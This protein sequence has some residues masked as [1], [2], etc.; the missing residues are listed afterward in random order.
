MASLARRV[1]KCHTRS[2]CR[3]VRAIIRRMRLA[4]KLTLALVFA[5]SAVLT[6]HGVLAARRELA[7]FEGSTQRDARAMG[8]TL[9]AVVSEI[10]RTEGETRAI[11]TIE[12]AN[13]REASVNF[14]FV[15]LDPA[16]PR[17]PSIPVE[18][19]GELV[20]GRAIVFR[21]VQSHGRIVTYVPI[22]AD[23]S[24][25]GAIEVTSSLLEQQNY[26]RRSVL[27]VA[28][29]T[30]ATTG[31]AAAVTILLGAFFVGRPMRQLIEKAR[32]IGAGDLSG[33]LELR[34]RDELGE[35]ASEINAMC[36]R[37]A[38]ARAARMRAVDELRHAHRLAVVGRLAAGVAHELGTPL[39]VVTG[40]ANMIASGEVEGPAAID[41][42]NNVLSAA[43]RMTR[44]IRAL[45]DFA[46]RGPVRK[47][48]QSLEHVVRQVMTLIS[49]ITEK[50]RIEV[51]V[52]VPPEEIVVD[53]DAAQLQQALTNLAING[54]DAM[55]R[56]GKLTI[57]LSNVVARPPPEIGGPAARYATIAVRDEG[58][59]ID[60]AVLEQIFEPFFTTKSAG[61]GTGL[62]LSVSFGIVQEHGGWIAV[63]SLPGHGACFTVFLPMRAE[64]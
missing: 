4:R 48:P 52:Q 5:V 6:V 50:R 25:R 64:S 9:V 30:A 26:V 62:G 34:Q 55:G 41:A 37:L 54:V 1:A 31:V 16:S 21:E 7:Y 35:L 63:E 51:D 20:R 10:W 27:S 58:P 53:V 36:D 3:G 12:E 61:E 40:W 19:I 57:A 17:K 15:S 11:Q 59:G 60:P 44:I 32:R 29:T 23:A 46:R 45:L 33:P 8:R 2:P 14:R 22:P 28:V 13:E 38:E 43:S 24:G 18:R 56:D 49:P 39:H 42:A 47:E